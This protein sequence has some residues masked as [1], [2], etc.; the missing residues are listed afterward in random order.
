MHIGKSAGCCLSSCR[1][2]ELYVRIL[3]CCFQDISFMSK[4]VCKNNL[5]SLVCKVCCCIVASFI[6]TD[7]SFL[8]NL[9]IIKTKIFYH[10]IDSSHVSCCITFV[11][12]TDINRTNLEIFFCNSC[13][14]FAVITR[15]YRCTHRNCHYC[16]KSNCQCFFHSS[17]SILSTVF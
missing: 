5:A 10:L 7:Q 3:S 1:M 13:T 6:F 9:R 16:C 12:I 17:S 11:L 8:N 15:K 2:T 14:T 4:T